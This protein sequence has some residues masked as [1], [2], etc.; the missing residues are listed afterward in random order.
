MDRFGFVIFQNS[1]HNVHFFDK[2][3]Y[4]YCEEETQSKGRGSSGDRIRVESVSWA[5]EKALNTGRLWRWNCVDYAC[6][7]EFIKQSLE[8]SGCPYWAESVRDHVV[9]DGRVEHVE[10]C[11]GVR[12]A[13]CP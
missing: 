13:P 8:Q 12:F 1:A 10:D 2:N 5:C 3:M 7:A 9:A 4:P 6:N 11:I